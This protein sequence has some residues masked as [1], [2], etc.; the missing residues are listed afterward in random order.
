MSLST[1]SNNLPMWTTYA[2]N[3]KGA[4]LLFNNDFF[5]NPK[6]E[7]YEA[8]NDLL[9]HSFENTISKKKVANN[10]FIYF[11]DDTISEYENSL[12]EVIYLDKFKKDENK[13][14][15]TADWY[16]M[17]LIF[18][19]IV[20]SIKEITDLYEENDLENNPDIRQ[21]IIDILDQVRFL[22]KDKTYE[23]EKEIRIVS[24]ET[25]DSNKVKFDKN[26]SDGIPHA[27]IE[28]TESPIFKEVILGPKVDNTCEISSYLS[29]ASEEIKISKSNIAYK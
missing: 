23:Y 17:N 4:C 21:I 26:R 15:N 19:E 7:Y 5:I 10:S 18:K 22:F 8:P 27:Y 11:F 14:D 20:K 12:Y 24:F 29:L 13:E 6:S 16:F 28:L 25:I 2:D 9:L 3:C 1:D